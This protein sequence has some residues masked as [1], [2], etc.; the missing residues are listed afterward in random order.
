MTVDP[1]AHKSDLWI[2][3][4]PRSSSW[5][6]VIDWYLNWQMSKGLAYAGLHLPNGTLRLAEDYEV[7]LPPVITAGVDSGIPLL[8]LS[9]GRLPTTKCV[10]LETE[11]TKH[12]DWLKRGFEIALNLDA[13][14]VHVFLPRETSKEKSEQM[15]KARFPDRSTRFSSDADAKGGR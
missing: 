2:L 5:F 12:E 1:F 10:V 13:K 7:Q 14:S 11:G 3:P 15:W 6:A 9:H 4:P 8:V